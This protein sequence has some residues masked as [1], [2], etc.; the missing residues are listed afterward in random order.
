MQEVQLADV[1]QARER[2]AQSQAMA[3]EGDGEKWMDSRNVW[4]KTESP[5][6]SQAS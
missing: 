5:G 1:V 6:D 4:D 2:A 3:G